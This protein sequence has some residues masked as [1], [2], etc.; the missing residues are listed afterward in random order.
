MTETD[1]LLQ[2]FSIMILTGGL[3]VCVRVS[4]DY[5]LKKSE[6]ASAYGYSDDRL[7]NM[8]MEELLPREPINVDM[9][10]IR[11]EMKG[12]RILV[13]GAAG[14][15]GSELVMSLAECA[16]ERLILVDQA[17]TPLHSLRLKMKKL[18]AKVPCVT[19][20]TSICYKNR[21]EYVFQTYHPQI[22]F[23]AAAYKHV[24]MMEENPTESILNNVE[25]TRVLADMAVAYGTERFVMISTDKAVNPTSV[26]GCS[27]RLC[28]I[29]C[30]SL[31]ESELN[32]NPKCQFITTRFGNVLGSNGS[33]IP[34]FREQIRHG[35]PV[36]V[37]HP[38]VIRYF[39]L[40]P[41]AC[42]LVLEAATIGNG[43]EIFIFDMGEPVRIRDLAK[44]MIR[45]SGQSHIDIKYTGLRPGEKLYEEVLNDKE[46]VLPT[47]HP[48]IKIA[49]VR[50]YDFLSVRQDIKE[51]I[52]TAKTSNVNKLLDD[53]K[54]IV[55]EFKSSSSIDEQRTRRKHISKALQKVAFS[56]LIVFS[57]FFSQ[58]SNA[59]EYVRN[60]TTILEKP[61]QTERIETPL[62]PLQVVTNKFGK[63]WFIFGTVG[64]HTF[65]GDYSNL[66]SFGGTISPE[67]DLGFGKW[68][69]PGVGLKLEVIESS[70]RGYTA[71]ETGHYGDGDLITKDDGT[72]YRNMKRKWIDFSAS[73]QLNLTRLINGYEG[74]LSDKNMNQFLVSLGLG[75]T[76]HWLGREAYGSDNNLSAHVE[77]QYS[78]F[79]TKDKRFSLDLKLRGIFY[80][81]EYDGEH[82][83]ESYSAK[84]I[85]FNFGPH[86]GFTY[87]LGVPKNS[88]WNKGFTKVYQRDYREKTMII[89]RERKS[90]NVREKGGKLE[91]G[92]LTFFVFF[93]NNY[94]GRND[95]PQVDSSKVNALDYLAAGIFTQKRFKDNRSVENRLSLGASLSPLPT[96]DIPTE[97]ADHDLKISNVA[98]GYELSNQP[99]S[100]TL[101]PDAM[102]HFQKE[103]GYYYA[104]IIKNETEWYYR[105]DEPT[106]GQKLLDRENYK[107]SNSFGLNSH[108]GL[109]L[110]RQRMQLD[111][112][113]SLV[114]FADVYAAINSN[115]GY[116]AQFTDTETVKH[117]KDILER[118]Y[119]TMIQTEGVSTSQDN[120]SGAD[121]EQVSK[122]RNSALSQ[123][124]AKTV[125]AWLKSKPTLNDVSS[126][127]YIV[128]QLENGIHTVEGT[129]TRGLDA[130]LNRCTKVRIHYMLQK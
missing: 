87:Y 44:R 48:K 101:T 70:S 15:I 126:Q 36:T 93:P 27:K 74:Y 103:A 76:H 46:T 13:T 17:E 99:L 82:G 11:L 33:V 38:D 86:I 77:L 80:N 64:V 45:L 47:R 122:E 89:E 102:N 7:L 78:R 71:Y 113:D 115:N 19:L 26:M 129:S 112:T 84:K 31:S 106:K 49:R 28:E 114:S 85:D 75:A 66:G 67:W 91:Y 61:L 68:F 88:A 42:K 95:A 56:F 79:F 81:S 90:E 14:S 8:E 100:L 98:R 23:H 110:I 55:P 60:D 121:S 24:P 9:E 62:E 107:E 57:A 43:G 125:I 54:K 117:V 51:L 35:G 3:R 118:G 2:A 109:D 105:V 40:I 92:T 12:K 104:P 128:S 53:M 37:T 1:I 59:Q 41:E 50:K 83:V 4:Y 6:R 120:Y 119:I 32:D 96:E 22:V 127:I 72:S 108:Q 124:R 29:Y 58:T 111:S 18:W 116:I 130:K 63:N 94:S 10:R 39:M 34:V 73:A 21:M 5:Y 123:N 69:T 52:K 25:G 30:Q 65:R 97:R 16:P 20:V